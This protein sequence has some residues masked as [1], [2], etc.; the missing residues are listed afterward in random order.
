MKTY[1]SLALWLV[2]RQKIELLC[3]IIAQSQARVLG[4]DSRRWLLIFLDQVAEHLRTGMQFDPRKPFGSIGNLGA[5]YDVWLFLDCPGLDDRC[6]VTAMRE[7]DL[8]E[9]FA[10]S[11]PFDSPPSTPSS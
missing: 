9:E 8:W 7:A 2:Q 1:R 5:F 10:N 4:E 6:V 3:S 11:T